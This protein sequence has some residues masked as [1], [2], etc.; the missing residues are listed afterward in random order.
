MAR[1][2]NIKCGNCAYS[3]TGGYAPGYQSRLGVSRVKCSQCSTINRTS[4]IPYSQFKRID[5]FVF[6]VGRI[7]R[8]LFKGM[9]Y[10]GFLGF[11]LGS[12]FSSSSSAYIIGGMIF[13][14][15]GNVIYSYFDIKYEINE[16][17]K[18]E[19]NFETPEMEKERHKSVALKTLS[20]VENLTKKLA[21]TF[22]KYDSSKSYDVWENEENYFELEEMKRE[23]FKDFEILTWPTTKSC[24]DETN[25]IYYEHIALF[26]KKAD[27]NRFVYDKLN[28]NGPVYIQEDL[29]F[30]ENGKLLLWGYFEHPRTKILLQQAK[31]NMSLVGKSK[32]PD[33]AYFVIHKA[34]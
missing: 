4:S 3:F 26:I 2:T 24:V 34:R 7:L 1:Y 17:E 23:Y 19:A 16:I 30:D 33:T 8:I 20:R 28:F 32:K 9:F 15:I 21:E 6:W 13:G 22:P 11:G 25:K 31:D 14:V 12:L 27:I 29:V 5:Y 10:G 18:E